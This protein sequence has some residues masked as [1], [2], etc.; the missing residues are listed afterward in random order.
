MR[1]GH[2]CRGVARG[3]GVAGVLKEGQ[4]ASQGWA[5]G[6]SSGGRGEAG[7]ALASTQREQAAIAGL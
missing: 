2:S 7:H 3:R 6:M 4:E 1:G 5:Q